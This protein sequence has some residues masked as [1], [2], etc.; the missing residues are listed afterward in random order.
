MELLEYVRRNATL[1][2][3]GRPLAT[4]RPFSVLPPMEGIGREFR[5]LEDPEDIVSNES[6][7]W[8]EEL[9]TSCGSGGTVSAGARK[10]FLVDDDF[11]PKEKR[12]FAFGADATRRINR[13]AE[14]LTDLGLRGTFVRDLDGVDG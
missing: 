6:C 13:E 10:P 3:G 1:P 5:P 9:D 8:S 11:E 4:A 14:A 7:P 2:G 12:P